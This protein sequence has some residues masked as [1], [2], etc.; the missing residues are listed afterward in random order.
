MTNR[1]LCNLYRCLESVWLPMRATRAG[2]HVL[3]HDNG[4]SLVGHDDRSVSGC[5]GGEEGVTRGQWSRSTQ[6]IDRRCMATLEQYS[7]LSVSRW[8]PRALS[9]RTARPQP[10]PAEVRARMV[11]SSHRLAVQTSVS[12]L[13][14]FSIKNGSIAQSHCHLPLIFTQ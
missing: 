3:V 10:L 13:M 4:R 12:L 6:D 2:R 11:P 14:D 5:V 9:S 1:A 7:N 8:L